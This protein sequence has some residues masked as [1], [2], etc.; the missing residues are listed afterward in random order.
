[1]IYIYIYIYVSVMAPNNQNPQFKHFDVSK[2]STHDWE[3]GQS[4]TKRIEDKPWLQFGWTKRWDHI[5]WDIQP[6]QWVQQTMWVYPRQLIQLSTPSMSQPRW[7]GG[8]IIQEW[9]QWQR[10]H[11]ASLQKSRGPPEVIKNR[12]ERY[13][14][15]EHVQKLNKY[16]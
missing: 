10:P 5:C 12:G 13:H 15:K 11:S 2:P 8:Q 6:L 16:L 9:R 7:P 14:S 1:M 3:K 4:A